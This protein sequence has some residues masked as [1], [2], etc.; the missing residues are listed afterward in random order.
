PRPCTRAPAAG[1]HAA[2]RSLEHSLRFELVDARGVDARERAHDL[3]G[4]LADRGG[5]VRRDDVPRERDRRAHM[6]EAAE[7]RMRQID[8]RAA[9]AKRRVAL[10][11]ILDVLDDA[12]SDPLT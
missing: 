3:A 4:V 9:L 10:D 2:P 8:E 11:E 7:L 6:A 12:G 5:P 1:P